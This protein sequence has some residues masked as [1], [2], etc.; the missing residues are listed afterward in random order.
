VI[1][2]RVHVVLGRNDQASGQTVKPSAAIFLRHNQDSQV[3]NMV[4]KIKEISATAVPGLDYEKVSVM[5]VPVRDEVLIPPPSGQ[6]GFWERYGLFLAATGLAVL[7]AALIGL[8]LR[9]RGWRIVPAA[10]NRPQGPG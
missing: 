8:I 6:A 2:A 9:K 4:A 5:L 3:E 7:A 1:T 10:Q